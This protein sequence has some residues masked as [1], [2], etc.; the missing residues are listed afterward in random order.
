MG[1]V[2]IKICGVTRV[3]DA[4]AAAEAGADWLGL[5]FYSQSPRCID[6]DLA[7]EIMRATPTL[8]HSAVVVEPTEEDLFELSGLGVACLQ[9]HGA[10]QTRSWLSLKVLGPPLITLAYG[11]SA[12]KDWR[13]LLELRTRFKNEGID[14]VGILVDAKVAGQHGGTGQTAPWELLATLEPKQDF[15]LAGGLAPENVAEAIRT[16]KPWGVDVASGVES[17]PGIKDAEKIKRF[18]EAARA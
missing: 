10:D 2:Q 1:P 11:V 12:L 18:V 13:R 6:L 3:A 9:I 17:A 5:N 7:F 16:V 15:F 14:E 8:K 4:I